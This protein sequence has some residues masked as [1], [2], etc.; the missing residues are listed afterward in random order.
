MDLSG[1]IPFLAK[2]QYA[3]EAN[4]KFHFKDVRLNAGRTTYKLPVRVGDFAKDD[5]NQS[6]IPRYVESR[7]ETDDGLNG[8]K[9]TCVTF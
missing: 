4:S 7:T 6:R 9:A 2:G 5:A 8:K 3:A 1:T